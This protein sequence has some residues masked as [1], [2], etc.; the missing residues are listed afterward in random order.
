VLALLASL[1]VSVP[2]DVASASRSLASIAAQLA[3]ACGGSN[4]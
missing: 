1:H 2:A 3:P 4:G